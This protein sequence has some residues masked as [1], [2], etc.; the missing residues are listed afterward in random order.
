MTPRRQYL[1]GLAVIA[2]ATVGIA[3]RLPDAERR[4]IWICL[5]VGM[6]VQGPVGWIL[7]RSIDTPR[8]FGMMVLGVAS[9]LALVGLFA[10][11]LVPALRLPLDSTLFGIAG[12]LVA[13]LIVEVLAVLA[14]QRVREGS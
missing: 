5:G 14:G 4:A 3:L 7:V 6:A 8:F 1:L 10:L 2:L 11:V 12:I 13:L 9:R